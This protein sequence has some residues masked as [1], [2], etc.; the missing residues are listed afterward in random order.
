M[1]LATAKATLK[2]PPLLNIK[3]FAVE[4]AVLVSLA[5]LFVV[6]LG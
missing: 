2:H 4:F 5:G 6:I 3:Q 1:D